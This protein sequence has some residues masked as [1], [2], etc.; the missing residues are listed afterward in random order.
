M[1]ILVVD[2][3]EFIRRGIRAMLASEPSLTFCGEAIDGRD[4][5][6][7]AKAL[8][9]DIVVMDISMPNMNGLEATREIKR[10]LPESG[11]VIL[12]QH[13]TPEVVRQAFKMGARGYV[14]KSAIST[15]LL[16]AITKVHQRGTFAQ[17]N[18]LPVTNENVD[19]QEILQ[20]SAALEQALRESEE[21]LRLAQHVARV[22]TFEWNIKTG[23]NRWTPELE[24]MYGLA[25]GVFPGT[26]AAWEQLLHPD[27]REENLRRVAQA[28]KDG[29]F[30]GEWRVVWPDGSM[31]WLLGRAS[32]LRD[33]AGVPERMIGVNIDVTERKRAE[34]ALQESERRFRE[35]IDAL[36]AA[37]Y[38][39]DA[40]G[41][42]T[43]FNPA[44][45]EF[46]GRVPEVGTDQWCV[47]WKMFRSDGTPLPHDQCPMAI[48]LKEGRTMD[49]IEAI[50]ERP[51][52]TRVWFTPYPRPLHDAEGKIAGGINML[53]DI[54][55]RKQAERTSGLLAAIVDSSDDAIVSKSLDGIITSWNGSA[56]RLFG[57][58]AEEAIGQHISLIIPPDHLDEEVTI[59]ESLKRGKR[60][61]HFETVRLRKDG[62]R[63]DISLTISPV[64]DSSGLIVGASKVA[65]N[66]TERKQ[67][68][69]TLRESEE[70][71][72][73]I[74]E[75]TPECVKLVAHD[76][77]LLQMNSSGLT[78]IGANRAELVVGKSVYDL[79][80]PADRERFR[81]FNERVCRG[82]RGSLQ[83]D[84]VGLTGVGRHM[85]THAAPLR[86]PDGNIVQL[87]V[88]SDI[89][90]RKQRDAELL[91]QA[92]L[93]DLS[94]NA[95]IV[96]DA[97]DR[98]AYWNK[99]AE[100]LYGWTRDEALG[101]VTHVLFQTKFPESLDSILARLRRDGRWQ[102]ELTHTRK[103][104][105]HLTVI[106][107]WAL[108]R[109]TQ[110]NLESTLEANIDI[111]Q[112]KDAEQA[113]H[114][115][116]ETLENRVSERTRELEDA[117][118]KLRE[119]S[120]RLLQ[121]QDEE[122]RRIARELHDGVGQLLVAL[123]MN[124]S[125]V[126]REKTN[127]SEDA[128]QCLDENITLIEQA[129]QEIRT[130]SHLLHPPLLDEVGL[131]SALRWYT[132]G[133]A[134]RSKISVCL[135][136]A[137]SFSEGL[138]RDLALALFRIVQECLTN[139][140]RHSESPKAFVTLGRS[141]NEIT[142]EVKDNG[143][144]VSPEIQAKIS[145]GQ[146]A[147]VGFRGMRERIRQFGGRLEVR[148]GQDGTQVIA[149]VPAPNL[150]AIGE[151][152]HAGIPDLAEAVGDVAVP[153]TRR[154]AATILCID[155]EV[156]RL[157]PRKLLLKSAGHRVLE[158]RS[159]A[160]GI[161]LFH[162]EKVD[163]VILDYWMTGM[164]G[165][166]VATELKRINPAVPIMVVSGMSDLPAEAAGL[167]DQWLVKGSLRSEKLLDSISTLLER[168]TV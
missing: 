31:H 9:P 154:D 36:P 14:V 134:E 155:D 84:I 58:T 86:M 30:E 34:I 23:V 140:H 107:R 1:R 37:I 21:R 103:N 61:D 124:V 81:A 105:T 135:Q 73:A 111:T 108:T 12:S 40:E 137:P 104:G 50:A 167:V 97:Q 122:R 165:T 85:E 82:E 121:T 7:K 153:E 43:H 150:A 123:K 62:R 142:L 67:I 161:R 126:S 60:V 69:R 53:V 148:S 136:M 44:A 95:V 116:I 90:N 46:S 109:D 18:E 143:K 65:R 52:G 164:K 159:G 128:R 129:S 101:Q 163:A 4:A 19:V 102:G 17:G 72:R 79:I 48:A 25:P 32:I 110:T 75:T 22:G 15:D 89:T 33:Q 41:R 39:T 80:A 118:D 156:S 141:W 3:H 76:G 27:D 56:E 47:S 54:T 2:D 99:G 38:T 98:I 26:Q 106:S 10:L 115:L 78:M 29:S 114:L 20:R 119:L 24:A 152:T 74:V 8:R 77:T 125:S 66:V 149:I 138:P 133:F 16:A 132:E 55:Q 70:R 130:M 157:S 63:L 147:G 93:L 158:A 139:V 113:L 166:S 87:A 13:E 59:L 57:Y 120:A 117:T 64:R 145:S 94:F 146:S 144:G 100:E 35:M 96:R 5:V 91:R 51:D 6:E 160:D 162:S 42:L 168:R 28:M 11:I 131:E 112:A 83:F 127:L 88:T 45:A 151:E 68:E 71:F 49:G 92:G